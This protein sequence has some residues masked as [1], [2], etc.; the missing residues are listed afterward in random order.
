MKNFKLLEF[1]ELYLKRKF[2]PGLASLYTNRI[3]QQTASGLINLFLP[4]FLFNFFE[5]NINGVILFYLI[6]YSLVI[7]LIPLG[8]ILM[9]RIGFKKSMIIGSL[10][11]SC[12]YVG[13]YI[14]SQGYFVAIFFMI[15][16]LTLSRMFYWVPYHTDFAKLTNKGSRGREVALLVSIASLIS[17]ALPFVS[18]FIIFR[19]GFTTLFAMALGIDL[20]STLPILF[21]KP[22]NEK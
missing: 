7:F 13:I 21:V 2:K 6:G 9:T 18:A 4:I 20:V 14:L 1:E 10:F 22:I 3:T 16:F 12:Y 17:I 19:F 8:A 15:G 11:S 5:Q